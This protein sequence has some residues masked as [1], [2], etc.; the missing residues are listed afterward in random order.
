MNK[1]SGNALLAEAMEAFGFS[2]EDAESDKAHPHRGYP[3]PSFNL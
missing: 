2:V 1:A 3:N